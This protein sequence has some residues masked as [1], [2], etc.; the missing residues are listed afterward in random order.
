M[1]LE[2]SI[3]Y[4]DRKTLQIIVER[5]R[6]V[7]VRAPIHTSS[8]KIKEAVE[9]KKLWLYE[10]IHHPQ[11]YGASEDR[12]LIPGSSILYLGKEYRLNTIDDEIEGIVFDGR[13]VVSKS[14]IHC[15]AA[16]LKDWYMGQAN[17]LL[18]PRIKH[19]A[20]Q[21]GVDY[22]RVLISDLK[23]R[24]GSCTP[25][26]NLNFNW[27]LIKAPMSVIEYV[28]V[29]ELAHLL[30]HNHGTR[31]WTI[32]KTQTPQYVRAKDWLK[33]NGQVLD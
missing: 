17:E 7:V 15:V 5:D 8:E 1:N 27:R 10:K 13:F 19:Y 2:Y 30:E 23:Y 21:I 3:V 12:T 18:I 4:S 33:K 11:K 6:S 24:W 20:K 26:N 25:K 14:S 28:I 16:L 32:V 9:K 29:H 22:S 31:F